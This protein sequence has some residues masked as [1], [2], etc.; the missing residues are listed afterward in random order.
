MPCPEGRPPL[1]QEQR[2]A[3]SS[4]IWRSL[5]ECSVGE[6][7]EVSLFLRCNLA[8]SCSPLPTGLPALHSHNV[9][10]NAYPP[11]AG[12]S[13]RATRRRTG[14]DAQWLHPYRRAARHSRVCERR[15]G[16]TALLCMEFHSRLSLVVLYHVPPRVCSCGGLRPETAQPQWQVDR[17]AVCW[18]ISVSTRH[19]SCR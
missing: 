14:A 13:D 2:H 12:L 11:P 15:K 8:R 18:T 17:A 6:N 19:S 3:P 1:R 7:V 10:M 4:C 5:G 16:Y 9:R